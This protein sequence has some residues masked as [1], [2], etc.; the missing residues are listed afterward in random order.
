MNKNERKCWM[1]SSSVY[2]RKCPYC[3]SLWD[4]EFTENIFV[5]FCP[6]CGERVFKENDLEENNENIRTC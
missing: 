5:N 2:F 4:R 6:R 1:D 3:E